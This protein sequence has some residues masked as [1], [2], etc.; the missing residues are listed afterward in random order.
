[1]GWV[2]LNVHRTTKYYQV[3]Y[4]TIITYHSLIQPNKKKKEMMKNPKMMYSK[5]N[6]HFVFI[7][8][9]LDYNL[10]FDAVDI[11]K[12]DKIKEIL[13]GRKEN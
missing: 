8:L 12:S 13:R 1:M 2:G 5:K 7:L 10:I 11:D 3:D 6:K 4:Y 9:V